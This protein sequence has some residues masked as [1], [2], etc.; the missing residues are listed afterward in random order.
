MELWD[1]Y[2][3]DG[4]PTGKTHV[5][6]EKIPYG[7]YPLVCEVLVR[8]TDGSFLCMKRSENKEAYPGYYEATAGGS[9]LTGETAL[10][11]IKRELKEETGIDCSNFVKVGCNVT[12]NTIYHEFACTVDVDKASITLQEGETDEYKW[13]SKEEFL[14]FINSDSAIPT[15]RDRF[16]DH[17]TSLGYI[18]K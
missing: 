6:G 4:T 11:C 10:E 13:M 5:R 1:L 15:Q 8:H 14:K 17:Y 2:T 18:K 16:I 7:Y 3:K 9:A 12:H